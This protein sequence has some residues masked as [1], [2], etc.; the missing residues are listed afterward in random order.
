MRQ[1]ERIRSVRDLLHA[2]VLAAPS[3]RLSDPQWLH[4]VAEQIVESLDQGNPIWRKWD[5]Q[6]EQLLKSAIGCW[7]PIADL[8]DFLNTMPGPRLTLTDVAQR[9]KAFEEALHHYFPNEELQTGCLEIYEREKNEGTELSAIIGLLRDY[10]SR[11]EERLRNEEKEHWRR[12]NEEYW[13]D[14]EKQLL[15]GADCKWTKLRKSPHWH[16]RTN[17][18]LYRL[19]P[20]KDKQW[21]LSRV[22]TV[23]DEEPI[24]SLGTYQRRGDATK[25]VAEMAYLPEPTC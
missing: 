16:C 17:G 21:D 13:L 11:E 5:P 7:V 23:S 18:R 19:S 20:T 1:D 6:R 25:A 15:S 24:A 9:Q 3:R 14:R 4:K 8:C 10:V 2:F 22:Q 12:I